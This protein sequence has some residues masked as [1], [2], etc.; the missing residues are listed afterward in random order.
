MKRTET[1]NKI[2]KS[3]GLPIGRFEL[4]I[5]RIITLRDKAGWVWYA[6]TVT[7]QRNVSEGPKSVI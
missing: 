2:T 3:L 1:L 5:L 4:K 7:W 6:T